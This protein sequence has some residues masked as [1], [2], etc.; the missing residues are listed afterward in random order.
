MT[1]PATP[2]QMSANYMAATEAAE[3]DGKPPG[4]AM[5][6]PLRMLLVAVETAFERIEPRGASETDLEIMA[7]WHDV[8]TAL[9]SDVSIML[10]NREAPPSATSGLVEG[11]RGLFGGSGLKAVVRDGT[12]ILD[13]L[14]DVEARASDPETRDELGRHRGACVT[15]INRAQDRIDG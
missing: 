11:L 7:L 10:V 5:V 1:D 9:R 3:N 2:A 14:T 4:A 6:E 15:V 8:L 13:L 12:R